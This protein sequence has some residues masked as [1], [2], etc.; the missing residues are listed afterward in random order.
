MC[1]AQVMHIMHITTN[2]GAEHVESLMVQ[3]PN[4]VEHLPLKTSIY[5]LTERKCVEYKNY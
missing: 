5:Y 4:E 3:A 2:Q 1:R